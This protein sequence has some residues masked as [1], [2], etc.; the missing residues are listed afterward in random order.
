MTS[1]TQR[2][3]ETADPVRW[4]DLAVGEYFTILFWGGRWVKTGLGSYGR[5]VDEPMLPSQDLEGVTLARVGGAAN[6]EPGEAA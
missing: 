1:R 5:H 4:D 3:S 2:L 6:N